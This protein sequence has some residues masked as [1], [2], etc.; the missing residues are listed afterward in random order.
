M[1]VDQARIT[2][3][4]GNGGNGCVSFHREKF[5]QNGGPD[6]GDGGGGGDVVVHADPQ[7][8]TL[9][10]FRYKTRY[11]AGAGQ[12]GGSQNRAG[13]RGED[14]VVR[15]PPGTVVRRSSDKAL[16]ADMRAPGEKLAV[17]R[18]GRGGW[19]NQRFATPT[20]QAPNFAKPGEKAVPVELDLE[21]KL[22]ADVG[23]VGFPNAGKS[24]I[25]SVVSSAKPK[26]ASYPFTT[27][28]PNIGMVRR[29]GGDFVLADL[30]GLIEGASGGAGLGYA[31][32]RHA[33]R[34]RLLIHVVDAS[35]SEGRDPVDDLRIIQGELARFGNARTVGGGLDSRVGIVVANKVD[36]LDEDQTAG[37]V[38]RLSEAA[39]GV[40]VFPASAARNKGLDRVVGEALRLLSEAPPPVPEEERE[41]LVELESVE[42]STG[43]EVRREAGMFFVDGPGM[44]RLVDSV[45]FG[46]QE[47]LAWFHRSLKKLGVID[48]LRERGAVQG[49]SVMIEGM[50]FDFT[51]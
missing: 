4:A 45:N 47:S 26:I 28:S 48:A 43:F 27:L 12:D 38:A 37:I 5:I 15:V 19:G 34:T 50:G 40:P 18:G 29:G 21:L 13:K 42:P 51:D 22:I 7:L 10:D 2:V 35:G 44:R 46:D 36:L 41:A 31:F 25:L 39:G 14:I 32:L 11:E 49:D 1:F 23:L 24:T 20:R 16:L 9:M 17:L 30:P 33:E 8:R 6:G 3:R